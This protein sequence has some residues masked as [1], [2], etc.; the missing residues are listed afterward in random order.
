MSINDWKT[1]V[2]DTRE[3][4]E[5]HCGI[6]F[7]QESDASTNLIAALEGLCSAY[8]VEQTKRLVED[9]RLSTQDQW[10]PIGTAPVWKA[11]LVYQE[12]ARPTK[13]NSTGVFTA[14]KCER[15]WALSGLSGKTKRDII[16]GSR[17][18]DPDPTHWMP[19]PE[20]PKDR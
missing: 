3:A 9:D 20:A 15:G 14:V 7:S 11:V 6:S 18:L 12:Q 8:D 16:N 2:C 5:Y 19:L 4:Y 10:Q 1:A 13:S 17:Y